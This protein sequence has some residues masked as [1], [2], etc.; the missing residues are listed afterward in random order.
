M[1]PLLH[2]TP[3]S[4]DKAGKAVGLNGLEFGVAIEIQALRGRSGVDDS[5]ELTLHTKLTFL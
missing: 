2:T 3:K 4:S 1:Q 5:R